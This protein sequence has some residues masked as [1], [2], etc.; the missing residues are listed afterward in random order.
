M[1][2]AAITMSIR[3]P[4][5]LAALLLSVPDLGRAQTPDIPEQTPPVQPERRE[6]QPAPKET[7]AEEQADVPPEPARAQ[8]RTRKNAPNTTAED[9]P[10]PAKAETT[11]V[12]PVA[13][14]SRSPSLRLSSTLVG[15]TGLLR[16]AAAEGS[17]QGTL[18]LSFGLDFFSVG[19]FIDD[20]DSQSRVGGTLSVGAAVHKYVEM[21]LSTRAQSSNNVYTQPNLL[22]AQGDMT[23]GVKAF[24]P[25]ADLA[26]VGADLQVTFLSGIG[27][28]SFDFGATQLAFRA[29][30]TSDFSKAIE[31][32]PLR[33]HLNAGII[34]DNSKNLLTQELSNAERFALNVSDF[35]RFAFGV[36][37]EA[38]FKYVTPYVEYMMELPF[39]YLATP[40]IVLSARGLSPA[41][42]MATARICTIDED[43]ACARP[44]VQRA[45][46]QH[47]TL[48]ARVSALQDFTFDAAV[49]IGLTPD[50]ATGVVGTPPYNIVLLAAYAFDPFHA[51]AESGPPISVPVLV[52][53]LT[54]VDK[55]PA[56]GSIVGM[57]KSKGD[58]KEVQGAVI[59]FDRAPPVATSAAGMFRSHEVEPGP[60]A[61]TITRDGYESGSSKAEVVAGQAIEVAVELIP[62]VKEGV[63][64]GRVVD[65]KDQPLAGINVS[66]IGPTNTSAT[67]GADGTFEAKALA[68]H[69]S[70]EAVQEGYLKKARDFEL[71]GGET[72]SLDVLLRKRPKQAVAAIA[73][74][75]IVV[76]QSVHFVTG[77]AR[78][79]PDAAA[80]LDNVVDVLVANKQIK[81]LR[82]EGHTDN[83]G[84]D[85]ANL[86]LS[87]DRA[88]AVVEYL[89][90]QGI[91]RAR[92]DA[93]GY[94]SSRPI[95]PN[96]TRRGREQNR[97]V[98]FHIVS[99]S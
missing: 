89:V 30:L 39:G 54:E 68:G 90:Q 38:P 73:K 52:P 63:I 45:I 12:R 14:S 48:G 17:P 16:I 15:E 74:N 33:F 55:T 88:A 18:R 28:T 56:T 29:L 76:N 32:V 21:W 92:L 42:G 24:Y 93:D 46:P 75:Q 50:V 2:R 51:R 58:G 79:E 1:L 10:A 80:V 57:V 41:Q 20:A 4:L 53:E 82:V 19:S 34:V 86:V 70:V 35:N 47:L 72:A 60:L 78:L 9:R 49:E 7:T 71:K 3:V 84:S 65:D 36:G 8:T 59:T 11:D 40:G 44:A 77:E 27:D 91:E 99:G 66:F 85:D 61:I 6:R 26:N 22:Q 95:A 13:R 5:V 81:K 62:S 23:L 25:L 87:R 37:L 94:G 98:E 31:Q 69:Y 83:V 67:T 96:L 97:R 43:A 64:K